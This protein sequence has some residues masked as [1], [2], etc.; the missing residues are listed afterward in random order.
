MHDYIICQEWSN[1]EPPP[2]PPPYGL[3][4]TMRRKSSNTQVAHHHHNIWYIRTLE[5]LMIQMLN[6]T[7]KGTT[8]LFMFRSIIYIYIGN[9]Y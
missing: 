2:E 4:A 3:W 7:S 1:E 8:V 6:S 9:K 5:L